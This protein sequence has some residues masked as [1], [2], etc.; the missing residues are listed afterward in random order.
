LN[1][2]FA[3]NPYKIHDDQIVDADV[4]KKKSK[5]KKKKKTEAKVEAKDALAKTFSLKTEVGD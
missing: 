4:D 1:I 2:T 5:S 3:S